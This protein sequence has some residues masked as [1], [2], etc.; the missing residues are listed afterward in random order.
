MNRKQKL[1]TR[2]ETREEQQQLSQEQT[3]QVRE[4]ATVEDLLRHDALHT[5]VPPRVEWRLQQAISQEPRPARP[6]WRRL[7]GK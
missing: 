2:A 1:T 7:F 3:G 4:F 5:P 6:W